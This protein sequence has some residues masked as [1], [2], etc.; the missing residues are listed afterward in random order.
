MTHVLPPPDVPVS[1]VRHLMRD[2]TVHPD[3]LRLR[4]RTDQHARDL[5]RSQWLRRVR[6][7]GE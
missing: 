4:D 5:H 1:K 6:G 3:P 2:G 7:T